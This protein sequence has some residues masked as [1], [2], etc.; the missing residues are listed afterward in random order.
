MSQSNCLSK[1][2]F[3]AFLSYSP[4]GISESSAKSRNWRDYIKRG[5]EEALKKAIVRLHSDCKSVPFK[6]FFEGDVVL[7][8]TP[9]HAPLVGKEALWVPRL[10]AEYLVSEGLGN[11]TAPILKRKYCIP[12]SAYSHKGQRPTLQNHLDSM[13][14]YGGLAS[15][16]AHIVVIDDVITKGTTL[17]AAASLIKEVYPHTQVSCFAL[18][19]TMGR[20]AEVARVVDP[21]L[22]WI[23]FENGD[24]Y[25][26]P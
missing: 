20:V 1:V 19:R 3:G 5:N 12:K 9:S 14:V 2:Q 16:P 21:C 24:V 6:H 25:R 8:P 4:K 11:F 15:V 7:V 10:I 22:G 23:T 26:V 13:E 17:L 18:L